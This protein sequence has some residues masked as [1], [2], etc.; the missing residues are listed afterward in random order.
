M[1]LDAGSTTSR[2]VDVMPHDL[3]LRVYTHAVPLAGRLT[4]RPSVDL[5]LLPGRVRTT[6]QAAV[7][8]DTVEALGRLRA[9]LAVVGTNAISVGHGLST[10]DADEAATKRAL[11]EAARRVV[12]VADATK[13]GR[14]STVRFASLEQVDVLVTDDGISD[15]DR[16]ELRAAGVEV[17]VA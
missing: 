9:D 14:E 11:V 7:G 2:L 12:V 15:R 3:Q 5:H 13:V 17:V 6:T 8:P 4:A 1:V 16:D 10:V